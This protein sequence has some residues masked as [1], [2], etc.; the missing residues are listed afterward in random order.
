MWRW[1]APLETANPEAE[2]EPG[3]RL[4]GPISEK[5][6]SVSDLYVPTGDGKKD[7]IFVSASF[8]AT[9]HFETTCEDII[10]IYE[11]ITGE[12]FDFS[13]LDKKLEEFKNLTEG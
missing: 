8:D 7:N 1:W 10:K 12:P 3:L 11:N 4:L 13:A 2:L 5:F 6:V 9:T